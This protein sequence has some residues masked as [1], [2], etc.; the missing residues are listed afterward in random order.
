MFM[1]LFVQAPGLVLTFWD[2]G[3]DKSLSQELEPKYHMQQA[4]A[5]ARMIGRPRRPGDKPNTNIHLSVHR[6][7]FWLFSD[8]ARYTTHISRPRAK[9][10]I[11]G[12]LSLPDLATRLQILALPALSSLDFVEVALLSSGPKS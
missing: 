11:I 7:L 2:G 4:N 3:W 5:Q 12:P 10:S 9:Q 6:Y 8:N 1:Y